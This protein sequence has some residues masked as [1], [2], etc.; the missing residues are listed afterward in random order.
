MKLSSIQG[1]IQLLDKVEI[2]WVDVLTCRHMEMQGAAWVHFAENE[3]WDLP[4]HLTVGYVLYM[5]AEKIVV[6]GTQSLSAENHVDTPMV[7]PLGCI[8]HLWKL[9]ITEAIHDETH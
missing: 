9:Q 5:D 4:V 6:T 3:T 8:T 2:R 1:I 7:F